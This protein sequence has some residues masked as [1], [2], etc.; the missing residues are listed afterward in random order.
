MR[1]NLTRPLLPLILAGVLTLAVSSSPAI[2]L[3]HGGIRVHPRSGPAGTGV[4]VIGAGYRV[5]GTVLVS[6]I[7]SVGT[8]TGLGTAAIKSDGTFRFRTAIPSGA[9][10][11]K[12]RFKAR[13]VPFAC[14]DISYANFRVT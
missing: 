1:R 11:G 10:L 4:R 7:D 3:G 9:A 13:Q 5:C 6:F 2:A 8:E 14:L 12:G